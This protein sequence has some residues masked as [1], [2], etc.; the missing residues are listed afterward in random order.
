MKRIVYEQEQIETLFGNSLRELQ[1]TCIRI[2]YI[3][4]L[5]QSSSECTL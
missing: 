1:E 5:G 2:D 3:R 4:F